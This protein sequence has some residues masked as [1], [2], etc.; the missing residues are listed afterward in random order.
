MQGFIS[1]AHADFHEG[2][3]FLE[4]LAP[5]ARHWGIEFWWD[6]KL[7]TGDAW[8]DK[9][10]DA[11]AAAKVFV[12]LVSKKSLVSNY[13]LDTEL[14]AMRA[15][16]RTTHALIIPIL[17][18]RCFWEYDFGTSQLAPNVKGR[19]IPIKSWKP[20]HDGYYAAAAQ[21]TEAMRAY[22]NLSPVHQAATV[23]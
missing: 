20:H 11:I 7:Q 16:A 13:I 3:E 17:L 21:T 8:N 18:N 10:A 4:H 1:Y 22:Y 12:V 14:P 19:L 15:Q 2:Q 9:I 5:A 23:P 6:P